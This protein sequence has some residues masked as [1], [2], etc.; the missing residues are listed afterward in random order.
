MIYFWEGLGDDEKL[1]LSLIAE[2]EAD[3]DDFVTAPHLLHVIAENAYPVTLSETTIRLTLEELFRNEI[4][5]KRGDDAFAY[6]I[7]LIRYWIKRSHSI[8]QVV[9]EV[10]TL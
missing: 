2:A 8:W 4:L 3:A 9:R 10:K 5:L 1:V 6:R 7:D